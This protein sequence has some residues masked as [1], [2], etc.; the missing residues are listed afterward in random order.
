MAGREKLTPED[1]IRI[2]ADYNMANKELTEILSGERNNSIVVSRHYLNPTVGGGRVPFYA[3]SGEFIHFRQIRDA[4]EH[5]LIIGYLT[6]AQLPPGAP[7]YLEKIV[8]TRK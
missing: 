3:P 2:I 6:Q 8:C 1:R 7:I 5:A 4:C